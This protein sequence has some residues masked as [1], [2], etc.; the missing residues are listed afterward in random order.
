MS[1]SVQ[2]R[3]LAERALRKRL[4]VSVDTAKRLGKSLNQVLAERVQKQAERMAHK[5]ER[6]RAGMAGVRLGKHRV[7]DGTVDVQLGEELSESLR[8]LKV[9]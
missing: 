7:P 9:R 4:L 1:L 5:Q 2:K 6:L 3:A 8:E